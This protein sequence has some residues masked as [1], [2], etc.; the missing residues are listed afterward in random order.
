MLKIIN[1]LINC[2][3]TQEKIYKRAIESLLQQGLAL[4]K[5]TEQE[6]KTIITIMQESL[7]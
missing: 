3:S 4:K 1:S 2:C 7:V 5:V 6:F